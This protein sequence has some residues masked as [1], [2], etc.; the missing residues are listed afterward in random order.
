MDARVR[1]RTVLTTAAGVIGVVLVVGAIAGVKALQFAAIGAAFATQV[2]P[3]ERVNAVTVE[4]QHWESHVSS[5]GSVVAV[6]GTQVSAEA[7]GVVRAVR[8]AAG[9]IVREGEVLVLLDDEIEQSQLRSAEA[10]AE[11]ARLNLERARR[12]IAQRAISQAELEQT[13]A[14]WKQ[15]AAQVDNIRAV[16]AKKVVRAPFA[17][18]VGIRRVS[19]GDFLAKGAPIVSL[20]TVDPVYVE[21]SVP[22]RRIAELREG[23]IV[24]VTADAHA[25]QEFWGEITALE[26]HVDSATRNIRVQATFKN[27]HGALKP[28]MFVAVGVVL[29]EPEA[30]DVIPA[31]AI[32]H[33]PHGDSVFVIEPAAAPAGTDTLVVRE[34]SVKLGE[35]RGDFVVIED[36]PRPGERVVATGVFKLRAGM[37]VVIDNTLAPE[38]ALSPA[39]GNG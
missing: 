22:Q 1:R 30:V 35:R 28:G 13:E 21:F 2:P 36:G 24:T 23:L 5:V 3:A 7:D 25:D 27:G 15:S 16:I 39:P 20:Q 14:T 33:A 34:R 18:K 6:Q 12:L 8:F 9:S 10:A 38:F 17:G 11:L 19:V 31:T 26:P 32:V 29:G 37:S 4:Q